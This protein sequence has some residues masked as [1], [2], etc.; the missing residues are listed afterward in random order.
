MDIRR[1][2]LTD[3]DDNIRMVAQ[4]ALEDVGGWEVYLAADGRQ[5]IELARTHAPDVI[6]LDVM[7]PVM[8]GPATLKELRA[9][10]HLQKT[11]VIFLTAKVQQQ[12][13][14]KYLSLGANGVITKPFDPLSLPKEIME[15]VG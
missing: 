12:E 9:L 4:I 5:A 7:M 8:D 6:L 11:P 3:D 1:V 13:V 14:E 15:I 10:P 2:L